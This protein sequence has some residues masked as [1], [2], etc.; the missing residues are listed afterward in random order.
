MLV[1]STAPLPNNTL[2]P[3]PQAWVDQRNAQ[4]GLLSLKAARAA[5]ITNCYAPANGF[6]DTV[7]PYTAQEVA[8]VQATSGAAASDL[9][10]ATI[11]SS[12]GLVTANGSA[13]P[14]G[15][16]AFFG[17]AGAS[18]IG[19]GKGRHP[20]RLM[21]PGWHPNANGHGGPGGNGPRASSSSGTSTG[22][23]ANITSV[24]T[25]QPQKFAGPAPTVLPY[26]LMPLQTPGFT[27]DQMVPSQTVCGQKGNTPMDQ[28]KMAMPKLF[29]NIRVGSGPA[30]MGSYSPDWGAARRG[31]CVGGDA[32]D[33]GG[34]NWGGL[35]VALAVS[36][37][38]MY[39]MED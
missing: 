24:P 27:P 33:A 3:I 15:T 25:D 17:P 2:T 8:S 23:T 29:P 21:F 31:K 9:A 35:L 38:I 5:A 32:G 34:I 37:G 18:L 19:G 39:V 20:G 10:G 28:P 26:N 16:A 12:T 36:F 13:A 6:I 1:S 14:G 4:I 22:G 7:G 11:P 30:G